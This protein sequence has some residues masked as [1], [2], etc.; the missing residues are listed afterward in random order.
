MQDFILFED[1]SLLI[2][3]KPAGVYTHKNYTGQN[4]L[5]VSE[6]IKDKL[7]FPTSL[8]L[9]DKEALRLGIV[10]RL[11]KDTSGI[12]IC[13]K[14]SLVLEKLQEQFKQRQVL[15]EYQALVH[16]KIYNPKTLTDYLVRH[17][18]NRTWK[19]ISKKQE[20]REATTLIEPLDFFENKTLVLARPLSGRTH[21]IRLQLFHAGFPI[22]GDKWYNLRRNKFNEEEYLY[23][24][25]KK[26]TFCHPITEEEQIWEVPLPDFFLEKI[27]E[28]KK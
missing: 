21:Q 27:K 9:N 11:D 4:G 12:M 22:V 26:I 14:N 24:C 20:G 28:L 13:A 23:L 15:K 3:N 16:G 17:K 10:H 5:A 19:M 25:S 18:K 6:F 7:D 1:E 2:I 8:K